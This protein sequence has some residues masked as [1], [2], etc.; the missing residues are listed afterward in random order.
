MQNSHSSRHA[1]KTSG[2]YE[3][4]S[5]RG[6][7]QLA[8]CEKD[9]L[10]RTM[11]EWDLDIVPSLQQADRAKTSQFPEWVINHLI[12]SIN[13]SIP[14]ISPAYLML[15]SSPPLLHTHDIIATPAQSQSQSCASPMSE[16][17]E[18][19][20]GKKNGRVTKPR[21]TH[22]TNKTSPN[23]KKRESSGSAVE[24]GTRELEE[25]SGKS[26]KKRR[27]K[28]R[29]GRCRDWDLLKMLEQAARLG[30]WKEKKVGT[31]CRFF[32]PTPTRGRKG[33][34]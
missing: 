5:M 21:H 3:A 14:R 34:G 17:P 6:S 25:K 30:G 26:T 19:D 20:E 27:R 31:Q 33:R 13:D 29:E 2:W 11:E 23:K 28:R 16:P 15:S 24:W 32:E 10:F 12:S 9:Q 8:P 7:I 4:R 22:P 1:N 18:R